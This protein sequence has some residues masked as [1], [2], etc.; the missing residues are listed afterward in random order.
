MIKLKEKTM[1]AIFMNVTNDVL[2]EIV[3]E[4]SPSGAWKKLEE[5]YSGKSLTNRFYFKKQ[6][7][8]LR[9]VKKTPIKKPLDEFNSFYE[10][11]RECRH[12]G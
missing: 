8:N 3:A 11:L 12:Q 9:M 6:L 1:S 4:T 5:L 2:H 10:R 7:Y